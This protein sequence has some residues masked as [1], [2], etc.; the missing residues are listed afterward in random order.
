[1]VSWSPSW[2]LPRPLCWPFLLSFEEL[3]WKLPEFKKLVNFFPW[4][5]IH[6]KCFWTS[7]F[8]FLNDRQ[9]W[10]ETLSGL[11]LQ[12]PIETGEDL[13]K[14]GESLNFR[15]NLPGLKK[16]SLVISDPISLDWLLPMKHNLEEVVIKTK[17]GTNTFYC[18]WA[19]F[20]QDKMKAIIDKEQ[21][22]FF[23]F[24]K[25]MYESN[26]WE[27]MGRLMLLKIDKF[28]Y[29]WEGKIDFDFLAKMR[30]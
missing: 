26:I 8:G 29:S 6:F 18:W 14:F 25:R 20:K 11:A 5:G 28:E 22:K 16:L 9:Y 17:L 7:A 3:A 12:M 10:K 21:I 23:M 13:G 24:V 19:S 4:F 30:K 15:L 1:M 27:V 2:L